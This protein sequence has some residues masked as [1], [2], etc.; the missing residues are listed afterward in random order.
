M[1]FA[2]FNYTSKDGEYTLLYD[3]DPLPYNTPLNSIPFI[4]FICDRD[5][6]LH[7][8]HFVSTTN[9]VNFI[10]KGCENN[11][12]VP[13]LSNAFKECSSISLFLTPN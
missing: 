1:D 10:D 8:S 2:F 4:N 11:I 5:G 13:A 12:V 3:C 6:D 7:D 9:V